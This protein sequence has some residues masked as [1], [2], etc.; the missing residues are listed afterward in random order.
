MKL[1]FK[2]DFVPAIKKGIK[3]HTIRTDKHNQWH[4]GAELDFYTSKEG[5]F[6]SGSIVSIQPVSIFIID[7][8]AKKDLVVMIDG[9]AKLASLMPEFIKNEGFESFEDFENFFIPKVFAAKKQEYIGKLI[10]W[11]SK[12]Y[13]NE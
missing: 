1:Q 5:V 8:P 13:E 12:R 6:K 10:H 3:K 11:T 2:E 7:N 4:M 9:S